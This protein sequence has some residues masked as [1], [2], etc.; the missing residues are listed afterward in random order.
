MT[1]DFSQPPVMAALVGGG[2]AAAVSLIVALMN[3]L[4][5]QAMHKQKLSFRP[6]TSR[7]ECVFHHRRTA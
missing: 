2:V 1:I 6:G 7:A 5:L 4:S 3:Q